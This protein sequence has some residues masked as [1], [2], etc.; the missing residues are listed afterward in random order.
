M[1]DDEDSQTSECIRN[2]INDFKTYDQAVDVVS[3]LE[4][5]FKHGYKDWL[6]YFDRFPYISSSDL[7]PDFTVLL[8]GDYGLIFEVKR[9]FPRDDIGF[10]KEVEQLLSYDKE[11]EFKSDNSGKSVIPGVHDIVIIISANQANQIFNRLD[12]LI[13]KDPS[14]NFKNNLIFME[15]FYNTIDTEAR[16]VYRKFMG[17]NRD[18]RDNFLPECNRLEYI[19]GEC[20]GSLECYPRHFMQY[21]VNQVLCNDTPPNLYTAVFLWTKIFYNYLSDEQK[22]DWPRGSSRRIQN[23]LINIDKLL[24]DLNT[25]YIPNGNI[26]KG[27]I[28]DAL[29]FLESANL[30]KIESSDQA[31]VYFRNLN[32]MIGRRHYVPE[33]VAEQEELSEY[34]HLI[35]KEFCRNVN[36]KKKVKARDKPKARKLKQTT[37]FKED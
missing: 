32:K 25:N 34:G 31:Y 9:T 35:A 20:A 15:Y 13:K 12:K 11:L 10:R 37:L 27:W 24:I 1:S 18:F 14:L 28:V 30:A 8:N 17:E 29:G 5:V 26:R 16:Y 21:K 4:S 7:T 23:I 36:K 33:G 19:L 6:T 2:L 22:K 3:C